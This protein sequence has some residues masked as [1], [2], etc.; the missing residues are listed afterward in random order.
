MSGSTVSRFVKGFFEV[1][2]RP[3]NTQHLG[4]KPST[5]SWWFALLVAENQW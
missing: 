4:A 3:L 5:G 2:L 1:P